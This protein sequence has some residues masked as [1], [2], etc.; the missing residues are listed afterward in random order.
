MV[1]IEN[2]FVI[3]KEIII[4]K[5]PLNTGQLLVTVDQDSTQLTITNSFDEII[6]KTYSR[7]LSLALA[8]GGYFIRCEKIGF[9]LIVNAFEVKLDSTTIQNIKLQKLEDKC[10][11]AAVKA[12]YEFKSLFGRESPPLEEYKCDDAEVVVVMSGS[13][14]GTCRYV[15]N[16]LR[17]K[18]H[19][20]G[21]L[22]L[23]M[24]RPFP[25]ELIRKVL[26]GRKKVAI[27]ERDLSL[28]QCGIYSQE[29]KWALYPSAAG[30]FTPIYG[31]VGGLGGAD[32]T[33]DLIQKAIMF[34]LEEDPPQ[35]EFIWL[36]SLR[37]AGDDYD[38]N[39]IKIS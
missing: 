34:T 21:L 20:V 36:G 7:E 14:A 31:F 25:K 18:G 16:T 32:I 22:K 28:G 30:R 37:E 39:T 24:F 38:R 15:I 8:T 11:D 4:H 27:I 17:E 12:N 13:A 5:L 23:K 6:E 1:T 9:E 19:R 3:N 10:V 2:Q 33:A 29:I 35:Q 26:L